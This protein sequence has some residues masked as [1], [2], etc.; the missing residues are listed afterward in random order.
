MNF[1]R[2]ATFT[3]TIISTFAAMI[4]IYIYFSGDTSYDKYDFEG[5]EYKYSPHLGIEV[6]QENS[7]REMYEYNKISKETSEITIIK[8]AMQ[9][10]PFFYIF[11]KKIILN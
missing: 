11:Q 7:K 2:I 8:V 9:K 6:Y 10:K 4:S 3:V 5:S 1:F